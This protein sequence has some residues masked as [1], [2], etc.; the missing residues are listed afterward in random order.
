MNSGSVFQSFFSSSPT[1]VATQSSLSMNCYS[2]NANRI[3]CGQLNHAVRVVGWTVVGGVKV[4][5]VANS[6]G[7]GWGN[8]GERVTRLEALTLSG[9]F[10]IQRGVNLLGVESCA[11][12]PYVGSGATAMGV[13]PSRGLLHDEDGGSH[14]WKFRLG[15]TSRASLTSGWDVFRFTSASSPLGALMAG[16]DDPNGARAL[17]TE[18]VSNITS[19]RTETINL[20]GAVNA[21]YQV[22][23]GGVVCADVGGCERDERRFET[24]VRQLDVVVAD[25]V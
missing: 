22:E 7:S 1:G 18:V 23:G 20:E 25:C 11:F 8:S 14:W 13:G 17:V 10:Y 5:R 12:V 15:A 4:W 2:S 3:A 21:S 16:V 6:W 24:C 9:Y 19:G